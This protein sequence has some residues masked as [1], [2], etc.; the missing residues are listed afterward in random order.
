MRRAQMNVIPK[1]VD[2]IILIR[3][4]DPGSSAVTGSLIELA[5][6]FEMIC[7]SETNKDKSCLANFASSNHRPSA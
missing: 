6:N 3:P 7:E 5:Q 2:S 4:I 1:E